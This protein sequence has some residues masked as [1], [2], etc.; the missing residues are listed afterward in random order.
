MYEPFFIYDLRLKL[1]WPFS[2][3][4]ISDPSEVDHH[5]L[6]TLIKSMEDYRRRSSR[7]R[8]LTF[9][10]CILGSEIP[11]FFFFHCPLWATLWIIESY[12]LEL[13]SMGNYCNILLRVT[14]IF[15]YSGTHPSKLWMSSRPLL[16][17]AAVL[18]FLHREKM[19]VSP[20]NSPPAWLSW[21]LF[22]WHFEEFTQRVLKV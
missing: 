10:F 8:M 14:V 21:W 3:I 11:S 7:L 20:H 22:E 2:I 18:Y 17:S 9:F 16:Q 1:D 19:C 5:C 6:Q 15:S 4:A 13:T 12:W